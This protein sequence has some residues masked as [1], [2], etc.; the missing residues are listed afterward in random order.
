MIEPSTT[1]ALPVRSQI[2][3]ATAGVSFASAGRTIRRSVWLTRASESSAEVGRISQFPCQ[4]SGAAFRRSRDRQWHS[5]NRRE[6]SCSF[7]PSLGRGGAARCR[8]RPNR[9]PA[10]Q[11]EREPGGC[12]ERRPAL[13]LRRNL[14]ARYSL[15]GGDASTGRCSICRWISAANSAT[16]AYRRSRAFSKAFI[17]IQFRSPSTRR[18]RD[19]GSVWRC[20]AMPAAAAPIAAQLS[21]ER[22]SFFFAND[23]EHLG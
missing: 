22:R 17:V 18:R 2:S 12:A 23:A 20:A 21:R 7:R 6:Q 5:R 4:R 13:C 9:D 3:A 8:Q 16:E 15:L 10:Q 19:A 1:A 14:P 11:D